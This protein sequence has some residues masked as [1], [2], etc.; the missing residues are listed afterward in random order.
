MRVKLLHLHHGVR[1]KVKSHYSDKALRRFL[2]V[3]IR[4]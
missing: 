1:F 2:L 4:F 3:L